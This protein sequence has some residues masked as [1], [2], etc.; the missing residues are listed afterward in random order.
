MPAPVHDS[1]DV[2]HSA[3]VLSQWSLEELLHLGMSLGLSLE[4]DTPREEI[5]RRIRRRQELL[6]ELDRRDLAAILV[7]AKRP[8]DT[9]AGK[10]ILVREIASI[11]RTD[12]EHLAPSSLVAFAKLRGVDVAASDRPEQIIARLRKHDGFWK[13]VGRWRRSAAASLVM[14]LLSGGGK[15]ASSGA[16]HNEQTPPPAVSDSRP[17]LRDHIEEH[18]VMAGLATRIRSA[19]DDYVRQKMD[20]IE[21][22][23]DAKLDEI[24]RRLTEWRDREVAN[25][26]KILRLTLIFTVLVAILSLGYNVLKL[27]VTATPPTP[28]ATQQAES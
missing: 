14:R 1:G 27:R 15:D 4:V 13:R 8:V 25:R 23:I 6:M 21:A 5:I 10:D 18:G 17:S 12:Y 24:D 19:A 16:G 22:R 7:W 28:P 11:Q 26:L 20:E 9:Q 2:A 3:A